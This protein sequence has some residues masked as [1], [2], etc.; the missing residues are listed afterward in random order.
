[1]SRRRPRVLY[2]PN[3]PYEAFEQR[4]PRSAFAGLLDAGL[5]DDVRIVSL[6][7]RFQAGDGPAERARLL[8]IV[9][10]FEP[11]II[12]LDNPKFTRLGSQDVRAWRS[13]S[14]FVFI[15]A[16]MD[17]NHWF[18]QPLQREARALARHVDFVFV[19][20]SGE[21]VRNFRR[22][23]AR[24]VRWRPQTYDPNTHGRLE[25]TG[26]TVTRDV[27]MIG[28]YFGARRFARLRTPPGVDDRT[29]LIA[30]LENEFGSQ[31]ALFGKRWDDSI[32][33]GPLPSRE[34]EEVLRRSWLG[35]VPNSEQGKTVR[36]AWVTANWDHF[37]AEP[38][39]SSDRLPVHLASG[40]VHFTTWHPGFDER[41][42]ELPFLRL[43]RRWQEMPAAIRSYLDSTSPADRIEHAKQARAFAA[44]HLRMDLSVVDMLNAAGAGIDPVAAKEAFHG[45]L[46]MLTEE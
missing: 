7:R 36:S 23:G 34:Q 39:Y 42:G 16:D 32:R 10:E 1:M 14:D 43:I 13:A 17:A 21:M 41:F 18:Y 20:G 31:F 8:R 24:D 25:I 46:R 26:D 37:P 3:E 33:F 40:T 22:W 30:G 11:T 4:G 29:R 28:S 35:S 19:P 9:Q 5:V 44:S 15:L 27:V 45:E 6:L 2:L 12:L 38:D